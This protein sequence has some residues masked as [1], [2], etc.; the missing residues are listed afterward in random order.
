[1]S[2]TTSKKEQDTVPESGLGVLCADAQADGVPCTDQ[3]KE[4]EHCERALVRRR[5]RPGDTP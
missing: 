5:E 1:M 3:G 2:K 4:C